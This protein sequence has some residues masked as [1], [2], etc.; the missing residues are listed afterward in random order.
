M[1]RG[2]TLNPKP[3]CPFDSLAQDVV[4]KLEKRNIYKKPAS[5]DTL[6]TSS[7]TH[8]RTRLAYVEIHKRQQQIARLA[9]A[10]FGAMVL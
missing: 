4:S 1:G 5:L 8:G 3:G 6:Q 2:P 9:G 10:T 7:N